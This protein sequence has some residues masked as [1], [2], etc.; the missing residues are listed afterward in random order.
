MFGQT[1]ICGYFHLDD[2]LYVIRFSK[3]HYLMVDRNKSWWEKLDM[4]RN[5]FHE[6]DFGPQKK[7]NYCRTTYFTNI[8]ICGM[9]QKIFDRTYWQDSKEGSKIW[10]WKRNLE[11]L[12]KWWKDIAA[13][14]IGLNRHNTGKDDDYTWLLPAFTIWPVSSSIP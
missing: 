3:Q 6:K 1:E 4:S 13:S 8:R 12:L 7:W 14:T 10:I 9:M 2:I 11:R 5:L